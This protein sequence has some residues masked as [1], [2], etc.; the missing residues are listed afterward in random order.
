VVNGYEEKSH[1]ALAGYV[2]AYDGRR[3]P[4]GTETLIPHTR[5]TLKKPADHHEQPVYL[6]HPAHA[7]YVEETAIIPRGWAP[8]EPA[9]LTLNRGGDHLILI[10]DKANASTGALFLGGGDLD[11]KQHVMTAT[12]M[13]F[14]HEI[15]H[16]IF[17]QPGVRTA[18]EKLIRSKEVKPV[19]WYAASN[20]QAEFFPE[21]FALYHCDPEWLSASRPDLFAW[22]RVLGTED[23]PLAN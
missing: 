6:S 22:F 16:V 23:L 2:E 7:G 20:P 4:F 15:G 21:A 1:P 17:E 3:L 19:T 18:F 11:Q 12:T 13:T 8:L 14:T 9:G 10:F 5:A